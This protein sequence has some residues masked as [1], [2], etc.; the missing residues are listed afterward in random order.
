M[1]VNVFR[2]ATTARLVLL[3]GFLIPFA[4][5]TKKIGDDTDSTWQVLL[6]G[7]TLFFGG[8]FLVLEVLSPSC[9][10]Y[11]SFIRP[12]LIAWWVYI[13]LSPLPVLLWSV[14]IEHYLKVLLPFILF[15]VGLAVMSA[16]ERGNI[17]PRIALEIILWGGFLTT[18]WRA[19]YALVVSGLPVETM[20]WQI[21]SPATP[22]LI[23][24]GV[25]GLYLN[26][27][28]NVSIAALLLGGAIALI[29][30]TR[31]YLISASMIAVGVYLI[32]ARRHSFIQSIAASMRLVTVLIPICMG[33]TALILVFRPD[34]FGIW[35]E[36]IYGQK[37]DSGLDMTWVTR[38]AEYRGQ[39][40]ALMDNIYT[41]L[42]GNGVGATYLWDDKLLSMLPF[43]I[44]D[45]IRWH[46]GHSTWIFPF[47]ASGVIF[48]AIVPIVL[49][50]T[51]VR[52]YI[53]STGRESFTCDA[54]TAFIIYL[55]YMGQSFTA[56]LM[57]ERY[58]ALILGV[59]SGIIL[60]YAAKQRAIKFHLVN[61]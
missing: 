42:M 13:V 60:I 19:Y 58:S 34:I 5:D 61:A 55:A 41:F 30:V 51:V 4:L 12:V 17:N 20:R 9:R 56:N 29:S 6:L 50:V 35:A 37:L 38:L 52:G 32:E 47:F 28:R 40:D 45:S 18:V 27:R 25:A 36:R 14:E 39:I 59:V 48:G 46:A 44:E 16:I 10:N 57:S 1:R 11:K 24:Y 31:S 23:G 21:L 33:M 2:E 49:L 3:F 8:L 7:V 54:I 53:T 26:A 22:F 43:L 15:G